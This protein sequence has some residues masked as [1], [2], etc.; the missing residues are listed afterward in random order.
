MEKTQE[1]GGVPASSTPPCAGG[2]LPRRQAGGARLTGNA[3]SGPVEWNLRPLSTVCRENPGMRQAYKEGRAGT[4]IQPASAF[5]VRFGTD[6]RQGWFQRC[7]SGKTAIIRGR[8]PPRVGARS[9]ARQPASS[10]GLLQPRRFRPIAAFDPA[11]GPA[12]RNIRLV[13]RS[14]RTFARALLPGLGA[15]AAVMSF[16]RDQ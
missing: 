8:V 14:L 1:K 10:R 9:E 2:L 15:S 5:A 7:K 12:T 4:Y 3:H 6:A 11:P 13:T 16:E